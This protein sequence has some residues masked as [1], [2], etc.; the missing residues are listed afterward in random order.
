M[1]RVLIGVSGGIAA[2]K[3]VQTARLLIGAGHA[4]RVIQTPNSRR[5]VGEATFAGITGAPVLCSEFDE[6]PLRGAY[7]GEPAGERAPIAHLAL[8]QRAELYLIAPASANTIAKLAHGLAD[9]LVTTAALA[10][11]LSRSSSRPR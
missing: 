10:A 3:A 5:F 1:A 2:Y 9:N 6:D 8:V 4:V 11:D 7:P